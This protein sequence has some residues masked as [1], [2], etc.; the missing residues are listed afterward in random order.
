MAVEGPKHGVRREGAEPATPLWLDQEIRGAHG[1]YKP[2]SRGSV[3]LTGSRSLGDGPDLG[4][5]RSAC[6]DSA[7]AVWRCA[8]HRTPTPWRSSPHPRNRL[9][10]EATGRMTRNQPLSATGWRTSADDLN[11]TL[12]LPPGWRLFALFGADWVAGDWLTAWT[13]LDLFLLLIFTLAVFRMWGVPA[14]LLAFVAFGLAYHEPGA[15]RYAWLVLLIPLA[16]LRVVPAGW[17]RRLLLGWKWVAVLALVL[18]LVPFLGKQIQQFLYPQLENTHGSYP[19]RYARQTMRESVQTVAAD[20]V[21]E[22][23]DPF[24]AD[25]SAGL[26]KNRGAKLR[27]TGLDGNLAYDADP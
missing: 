10:L 9:D 18:V 8:S 5:G 19:G 23:A 2:S 15:P 26:L 1:W 17:G 6:W 24:A 11:V 4:F 14:A 22:S 13:L 27:V 7:K 12:N 3:I 20:T 25:S 16:L 21:A